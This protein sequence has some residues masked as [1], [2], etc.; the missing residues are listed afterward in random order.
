[1]KPE[2]LSWWHF[3]MKDPNFRKSRLW[4]KCKTFRMKSLRFGGDKV[5][6][7]SNEIIRKCIF[8]RLNSEQKV[9]LNRRRSNMCNFQKNPVSELKFMF[10]FEER[11]KVFKTFEKSMWNGTRFSKEPRVLIL[12]G[13]EKIELRFQNIPKVFPDNLIFFK[14]TNDVGPNASKTLKNCPKPLKNPWKAFKTLGTGPYTG[15]DAR[16]RFSWRPLSSNRA[17][18]L[19]TLQISLYFLKKYTSASR[20]RVTHTEQMKL[21]DKQKK[22]NQNVWV[23]GFLL[24][25]VFFWHGNYVSIRVQNFPKAFKTLQ[26]PSKHLERDPTVDVTLVCDFHDD[27]FLQTAQISLKRWWMFQISL[28]RLKS[29]V[30]CELDFL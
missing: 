4:E 12:K 19:K 2:R 17:D 11:R 16:V 3:W 23:D 20:K 27:R 21:R 13:R 28:K 29:L 26:K 5:W 14:M 7:K 15:R 10:R 8:I 22:S 24:A 25:M 1:M 18:F 9:M 6:K 30:F